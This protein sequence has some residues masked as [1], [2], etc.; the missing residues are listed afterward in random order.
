ML[1]LVI[2]VNI[3]GRWLEETSSIVLTVCTACLIGCQWNVVYVGWVAFWLFVKSESRTVYYLI[4]FCFDVI[5]DSYFVG[6]STNIVPWLVLDIKVKVTTYKV[7]FSTAFIG[8]FVQVFWSYFVAWWS[9]CLAPT[10][11]QG[12]I[13][14]L[15][16]S[17][18]VVADYVLGFY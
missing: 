16:I 15:M 14:V 8:Y 7:I 12:A 9:I 5:S 6:V 4:V 13:F 2:M 3:T 17:M 18:E 10:V 11:R 1:Q